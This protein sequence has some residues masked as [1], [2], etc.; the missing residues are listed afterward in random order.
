MMRLVEE[1][2]RVKSEIVGFWF[3]SFFGIFATSVGLF[4]IFNYVFN[5][6]L[7][8][9]ACLIIICCLYVFG[10]WIGEWLE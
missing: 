4:L 8:F 6:S 5:H 1:D 9:V 2:K 3:G 10:C 7:N